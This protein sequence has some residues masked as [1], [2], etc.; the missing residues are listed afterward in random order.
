MPPDFVDEG[1]PSEYMGREGNKDRVNISFKDPFEC[2]QVCGLNYDLVTRLACNS[3]DYARKYH[4]TNTINPRMHGREWSNITTQEMFRFLGILLKISLSPVDG[5][6]YT[7]YFAVKDKSIFNLEIP[8][9]KGFASSVM[10]L[11]R[12]K[13]IRTAF[14]PED[15]CV[16]AGAGDKCYQL[17]HVISTFNASAKNVRFVPC[18]VSFNEGG[19]SCRSRYCPVRQYNKDKPDKFRVDFFIMACPKTYF[20]HHLDVYQGKNATNVGIRD[21]IKGVPTTQKAVI[22]AVLQ[23]EMHNDVDGARTIALDNRYQCPELAVL[24]RLRYNVYTAGTCRRNRIG[25]P[26]E[27][28]GL[29]KLPKHANRGEY[30]MMLDEANKV[31]VCQWVDSKVVSVVST[32]LDSS[33]TTVRRRVGNHHLTITCPTAVTVYQKYMLG[34]DKGD[35]MRAHGGGFSRKAHFK[36]WYKKVFLAILD[37]MLLNALVV[38]NESALDPRHN[39]PSLKRHELYT[40]CAEAMITYKDVSKKQATPKHKRSAGASMAHTTHQIDS[41]GVMCVVCK[42]EMGEG[43]GGRKIGQEGLTRDVVMCTDC[44]MPAHHFRP[45]KLRKV[46]MMP[47]FL[48]LTCQQ[49]MHSEQGYACWNRKNPADIKAGQPVYGVTASS[50]TWKF[51]REQ[52]GKTTKKVRG[53][54][55]RSGMT[56]STTVESDSSGEE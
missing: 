13:Q 44:K 24:L 35:Q 23:T 34:V 7:A 38:W 20:I 37:C 50:A 19:C 49:I 41:T 10:P 52:Y 16:A 39:R 25:F 18:K 27:H 51:L 26:Q 54:G 11:Y 36:K 8:G 17:R 33:I 9:S 31:Q 14:H 15:K 40:Y 48:G 12:F 47:E 32:K 6:G 29:V 45:L 56:R 22:N 30:K 3:N 5:G 55:S 42:L 21:E 46:H 2:V 28:L 4:L 53:R 43:L 1:S